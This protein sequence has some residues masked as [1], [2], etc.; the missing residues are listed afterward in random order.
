M[1]FECWKCGACCRFIGFTSPALDRGDKACINLLEDNTCAIYES[2]PDV[3]RLN[4]ETPVE[5]QTKI[6]KL[7]EANWNKYVDALQGID[8]N[9]PGVVHSEE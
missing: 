9:P 3:C 6:C 5:V 8:T 7:Q 1:A 4:P 2:R